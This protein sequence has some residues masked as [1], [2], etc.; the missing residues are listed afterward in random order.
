MSS[1]TTATTASASS[2][3]V[4]RAPEQT[5]IAPHCD[6]VCIGSA[7]STSASSATTTATSTAT[8]TTGTSTL[9]PTTDP[10]CIKYHKVV[11]GDTC[12]GIEQE[13]GITAAKV[14]LHKSDG[15]RLDINHELVSFTHH[16]DIFW[17]GTRLLDHRVVFSGSA[18]WSALTPLPLE[19][20]PPRTTTSNPTS[21]P[22]VP[23]VE[24]STVAECIK[25]HL[26]VSGD[27]C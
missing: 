3:S 7:S 12:V 5:G 8:D 26:V 1:N 21:T 2:T 22:A 18:T 6:A 13:Y 10:S 17:H 11:A 20:L 19:A 14:R 15:P 16:I 4:S 23:D 27:D 9:E 24:P 25:Y